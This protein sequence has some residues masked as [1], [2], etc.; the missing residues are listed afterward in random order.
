[1][2]FGHCS[3][4]VVVAGAT[5]EPE[6]GALDGAVGWGDRIGGDDGVGLA[7]EDAGCIAAGRVGCS[8][9]AAKEPGSPEAEEST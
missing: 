3:T 6:D 5:G 2:Q 9:E 4:L 1:M 7:P 8:G